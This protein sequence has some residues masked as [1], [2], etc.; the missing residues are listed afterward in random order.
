MDNLGYYG[1]G[2][3]NSEG[4]YWQDAYNRHGNR[5]PSC[6]DAQHNA[7][8]RRPLRSA[9]RQGPEVRIQLPTKRVDLILGGW[10]VEF[11][12][13]RAL[14]FPGDRVCERGQQWR[15]H[16][17]RQPAREL[18]TGRYVTRPRLWTPSSVR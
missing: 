11:L 13:Q 2:S 5:G 9:V 3:V 16:A 12:H 8:L 6:F 7:S 4:A 18:L 17:A 15:Q 14:G 10:N 1:C